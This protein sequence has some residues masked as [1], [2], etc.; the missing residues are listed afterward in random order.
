VS[1]RP[2]LLAR[3]KDNKILCASTDC[4]TLIAYRIADQIGND[5][6]VLFPQGWF[7]HRRDQVWAFSKRMA[8][9]PRRPS[10]SASRI[11]PPE[12]RYVTW[13][14]IL[15]TLAVC[16]GCRRL[17]RLDSSLGLRPYPPSL[18]EQSAPE[19]QPQVWPSYFG[20]PPR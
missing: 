3:V 15:P 6:Q 18:F 10:P 2:A 1:V 12:T 8:E 17:L 7:W 11:D 20:W 9:Q 13:A 4:G 14:E 19:G 5:H 16:P